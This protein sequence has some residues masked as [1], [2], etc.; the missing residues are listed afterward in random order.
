ML[1]I[2]MSTFIFFLEGDYR[3]ILMMLSLKGAIANYPCAWCKIHKS[4]R[5][6]MD[7]HYTYYNELPLSRSLQEIQ[8]MCKRS[9]DN[10]CC[11][12]QALFNIG[13]DHIVPDE[14]HLLLRLIDILTE[15][16]MLE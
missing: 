11:D 3:F 15:N 13:L 1:K 16:V 14:L 2:Q 6:K 10:F 4:G 7:L 9:N 8:D 12:K 5:W